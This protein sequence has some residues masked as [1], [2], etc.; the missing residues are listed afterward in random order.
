[1][2]LTIE[3]G[4]HCSIYVEHESIFTDYVRHLY[5]NGETVKVTSLVGHTA[6]CVRVNH[7]KHPFGEDVHIDDLTPTYSPDYKLL[8]EILSKDV[9]SE[10]ETT[11]FP[12]FCEIP[13]AI[14][15][16]V[17]QQDTHWQS[18]LADAAESLDKEI[19][20][21]AEVEISDAEAEA[22]EQIDNMFDVISGNWRTGVHRP[23][24]ENWYLDREWLDASEPAPSVAHTSIPHRVSTDSLIEQ[25]KKAIHAVFLADPNKPLS[26]AA[27]EL[28]CMLGGMKIRKDA[29]RKAFDNLPL[30]KMTKALTAH[31][32]QNKP[33]RQYNEI[34]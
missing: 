28:L 25:P 19:D 32:A 24:V 7:S 29:I 30:D 16:L 14:K 11:R 15:L 10:L 21:S 23:E 2:E 6:S 5:V 13:L 12:Y 34:I 8:M 18:M 1:M 20:I 33:A 26:D 22:L 31:F 17:L 3:T 9:I 27:T 4:M